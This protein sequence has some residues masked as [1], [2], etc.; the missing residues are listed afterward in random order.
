M[1]AKMAIMALNIP[2][3]TGKNKHDQGM[4]SINQSL[5]EIQ[6]FINDKKIKAYP[7]ILTESL[8]SQS[9]NLTSSQNAS[10]LMSKNDVPVH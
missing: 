1:D 4:Y 3:P 10:E 2:L 9:N 7:D 6:V 5:T 8:F